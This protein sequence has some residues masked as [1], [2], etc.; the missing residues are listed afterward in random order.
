ML[1]RSRFERRR[2]GQ[3]VGSEHEHFRMRWY[4]RYELEHLLA[5]TGFEIVALYGGFDR[6][7]FDREAREMVFVTRASSDPSD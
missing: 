6:R 3:V 5:R 4:Y 2:N 7:P 1:F